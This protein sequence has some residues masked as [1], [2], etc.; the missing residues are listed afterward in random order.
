MVGGSV[1]G[2][3]IHGQYPSPISP[4]SDYWLQRGRWIPTTPWESVFNSVGQWM[5]IEGDSNL[6]WALPNRESFSTCSL[7]TD[8]DLFVDGT[9]SCDGGTTTCEGNTR[10]AVSLVVYF[11]PS[12]SSSTFYS[13]FAKTSL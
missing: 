10:R 2:G 1:N 11:I 3:K 12:L 4:E 8:T 9:C 7:L 13:H 5:G 6:D